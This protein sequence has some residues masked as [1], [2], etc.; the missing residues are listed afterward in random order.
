MKW[1]HVLPILF[2][3]TAQ[4]AA[5]AGA[6]AAQQSVPAI[7][8]T[9]GPVQPDAPAAA[10]QP[11]ATGNETANRGKLRV[12][13]GDLIEMSVFGVP[14]LTQQTRVSSTGEA[15]LPLIGVVK[16][17]GLTPQEAVALLEQKYSEGGYLR[18]PHIAVMIKEYASQGVSV[19][20]EVA[21]PGVYPVMGA[22][23]L[24]D[25]IAAAGGTT[26]RAGRAVT[27]SHRDRPQEPTIVNFSADPAEALTNNV[28]VFPGDT[29][30]VS[31]AGIVYV[32]GDV[33]RPGGFVMENNSN[34]TVL[35]AVAL[36]GG[37]NRTAALNAARLI[38]KTPDGQR[39]EVKIE[40]KKILS[41]K[42]ADVP[43][44]ADDILF[45]P[46]SAAKSAA[47]RTLNAIIQAASTAA[48]IH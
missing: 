3:A 43:L 8:A 44:Q 12:G 31:K 29:V 27:I 35:Q 13:T 32:T 47:S 16:L 6:P 38:R 22:R 1:K 39:Q 45:I 36:A 18:N 41:A 15:S 46:G 7:P 4:L 42:A 19:M 21:H 48:V 26:A 14:E 9:Q 2:L 24:F 30:L 33:G 11:A 37:H 20:G 34:L 10:P 25:L 28:E 40:L 17:A 23:R 5:Q